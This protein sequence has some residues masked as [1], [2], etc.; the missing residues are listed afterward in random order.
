M[1]VLTAPLASLVFEPY[2]SLF[3]VATAAGAVA[4]AAFGIL[5]GRLKV[6]PWIKGG[7]FVAAIGLAFLLALAA[8]RWP[9][10]SGRGW[11]MGCRG[12]RSVSRRRDSCSAGAYGL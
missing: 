2:L 12:R 1:N 7:A 9:A 6:A 11:A 5:V 10:W 4:G 8:Q 3:S